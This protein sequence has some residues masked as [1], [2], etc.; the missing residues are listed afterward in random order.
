M[1]TQRRIRVP[2]GKEG[3]AFS[4]NRYTD[5]I[6]DCFPDFRT[7]RDLYEDETRVYEIHKG[8]RKS[9]LKVFENF[10][11]QDIRVFYGTVDEDYGQ[12]LEKFWFLIPK[13][14]P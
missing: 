4:A 7:T 5:V 14:A 9:I 6:L 13:D 2:A 10:G 12:L 1:T 11:V 3:I 8:T